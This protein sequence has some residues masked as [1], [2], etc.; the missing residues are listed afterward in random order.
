M[1]RLTFLLL[2]LAERLF[3]PKHNVRLQ[4]LEAQIRF[5]RSRINASRIVPSPDEKHE[6]LRLGALRDHDV[7]DAMHI[8]Q[9]E[10]Y[11]TWLRKKTRRGTFSL[12][13]REREQPRTGGLSSSPADTAGFASGRSCEGAAHRRPLLHAE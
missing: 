5:L 10:T 4:I 7:A 3:R 2:T 9:P 1:D 12:T 11:Q 6:L 8:V 13:L